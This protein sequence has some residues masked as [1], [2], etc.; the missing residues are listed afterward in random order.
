MARLRSFYGVVVAIYV[1]NYLGLFYGCLTRRSGAS[2]RK[3]VDV[4]D[5]CVLRRPL[6]CPPWLLRL[7][8]GVAVQRLAFFSA[9]VGAAALF[10][11]GAAWDGG[12]GA[13]PTSWAVARVFVAVCVCVVELGMHAARGFHRWVLLANLVAAAALPPSAVPAAQVLALAHS[14]G[15]SGVVRL[16]V[17]GARAALGPGGGGALRHVLESCR[18]GGNV[19]VAP[20]V[21][22]ALATAPAAV[23]D[24]LELA[25]RVAFELGGVL[26]IL[27]APDLAVVP[28]CGAAVLFHLGIAAATAIHF[29]ENQALLLHLCA[30]FR[31]AAPSGGAAW[32][33]LAAY[34]GALAF[35]VLALVEAFPLTHNGL[36]PFS[37]AQMGLV[38]ARLGSRFRL[39]ATVHGDAAA[40]S[41]DVAATCLGCSA[42]Q[43]AQVLDAAVWRAVLAHA[44]ADSR[45]GDPAADYDALGRALAA[46]LARDAPL[47]DARTG[48]ALDAVLL[49]DDAAG[50]GS[51]APALRS[52]RAHRS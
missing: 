47:C 48:R 6:W 41:C 20:A 18:R 10:V 8:C 17:R 33:G 13:A 19:V 23:L 14:Y 7:L 32:L 35:P 11:G 1:H 51:K 36:F 25:S 21:S 12:G 28:F 16:R 44:P 2:M 24:V 38:R 40:A 39:V 34:A 27:V 4:R 46:W 9:V 31:Y 49:V 37:E 15:G 45:R 42:R 29:L 52:W 5:I 3:P 43:P 22:A 30:T 50:R 26:A